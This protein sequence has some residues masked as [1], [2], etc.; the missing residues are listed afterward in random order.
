[1]LVDSVVKIIIILSVCV[2]KNNEK[3]YGLHSD[4]EVFV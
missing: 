2:E 3:K 1:M 4:P